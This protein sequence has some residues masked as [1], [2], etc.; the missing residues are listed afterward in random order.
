MDIS[1]RRFR[2][3]LDVLQKHLASATFLAIDLEFT[4][5]SVEK[6][7]QLDTPATRYRMARDS[8]EEF[9]P[10]QFGITIF[11]PAPPLPTDRLL[12]DREAKWEVLPFNFN[13]CPR[14]VY[15]SKS[16]R[17]PLRD[18]T[19][20]VQSSCALFLSDNGFS[21]DRMFADGI[22]WLR[23][24]DETSVRQQVARE[25]SRSGRKI[26]RSALS[27]GDA[28]YLA[29]I[30]KSI[31]DWLALT[32]ASNADNAVVT[33]KVPYNCTK[34]AM[35]GGKNEADG[36]AIDVAHVRANHVESTSVDAAKSSC[37]TAV[38][39][40]QQTLAICNDAE[41]RIQ[42]VYE[43]VT[44][45]TSAAASSA[46]PE[47]LVPPKFVAR[48][49]D[50][51]MRPSFVV[52]RAE[53]P[54]ARRA[55][56]EMLENKF[57]MLAVSTLHLQNGGQQ[58]KVALMPSA[59]IARRMNDMTR[60]EEVRQAMEL[61][62]FEDV[63]FRHVIDAVVAA[64]VPVVAHNCL[65]DLCKT[66]ANFIA[67]L[68]EKLSDFKMAIHATFP[69]VVDTKHLL[70]EA[71]LVAPW[72]S[73]ILSASR[74]DG[75]NA[76]E[77]LTERISTICDE[78]N[79]EPLQWR[80]YT[81]PEDDDDPLNGDFRGYHGLH[82]ESSRHEAGYDA[83]CTGRLLLQLL[84]ILQGGRNVECDAFAGILKNHVRVA[85]LV[86]RIC[87]A[88]CG[89]YS[90]INLD[91]EDVEAD[92]DNV[93]KGRDDIMVLAGFGGEHDDN[94]FVPRDVMYGEAAEIVQGTR[95]EV[96]QQKTSPVGGG[97]LLMVLQERP[98][99]DDVV[100]GADAVR[101]AATK[102]GL[103]TMTYGE[104][105]LE[106]PRITKRRATNEIYTST[107]AAPAT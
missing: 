35:V 31:V 25:H 44:T 94:A 20:S 88:S 36:R 91:A 19:F 83:L 48:G 97:R 93:Y 14:P 104:A 66:Y 105:L 77:G 85:P 40:Q 84:A 54:I 56:Y 107:V 69:L 4:G 68:P 3:G 59:E 99:A 106:V 49:S 13:L 52:D 27:E 6:T 32:A 74:Y 92:E 28:M 11:R 63:G 58:L 61:Q 82:A 34:F 102:R 37:G 78:E 51:Q 75:R 24:C 62:M 5:L 60:D 30:E 9:V 100:A 53:H 26:D 33:P 23:K 89:G 10:C 90:S 43:G 21:F 101:A 12:C 87:V 17:F 2:F 46:V 38:V 45:T 1:R 86:N 39:G 55:V 79:L 67:P 42:G 22:G 65:L 96:K 73:D 57:P 47:S 15:K 71:E 7:S 16:A 64:R 29:E 80:C 76:L 98:D 70:S 72:I 50:T 95:Y 8:A 81:N 18:R 103:S 41:V